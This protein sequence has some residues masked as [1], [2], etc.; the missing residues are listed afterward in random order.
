MI[1]KAIDLFLIVLAV[2]AVLMGL[3]DLVFNDDEVNNND[4]HK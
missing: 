1:Q 2:S 4:K 3:F